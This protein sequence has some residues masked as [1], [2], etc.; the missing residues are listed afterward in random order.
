MKSSE[1]EIDSNVIPPASPRR[2][3]TNCRY[4]FHEM[5]VGDSFFVPKESQRA[6][7]VRNAADAYAKR[8]GVG[9]RVL[10]VDGGCRCWRV[11]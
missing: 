1:F 6:K 5:E 7:I 10:Q 9:F 11:E 3:P 8:H 2:R 4:P